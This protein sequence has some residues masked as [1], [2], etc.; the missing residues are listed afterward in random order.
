MVRAMLRCLCMLSTVVLLAGCRGP[1]NFLFA[2]GTA[3][4]RLARLGWIALISFSVV[5]VV[6]WCLLVA[7]V[8]RRRG[9][10]GE[11]APVDTT[12]G[13]NWIIVGGLIVPITVLSTLFFFSLDTLR[14]FPM[15]KLMHPAPSIRVTARQWWFD[16]EYLDPSLP[17]RFHAP[18]ELHIPAGAPVNLELVTADVI[19]SFWVPKL[20]GKVDMV[21]GM[22]NR[23][24]LQADHPGIYDGECGEYCGMQ[25]AHMR[26]R[27][28]ADTP[29][30]YARWKSRQLADA[31]EPQTPAEQ[32]GK[33]D[34]MAAPCAVCHTIRG[35][36]A[37]GTVGPDLTHVGSRTRIAGGMLVNNTA[38]LQAW[39]VHAQSFKPGT[40]MPDI[41]SLSGQQLSE[42][43]LYLQ[44]LK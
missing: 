44:S 16:A 25:H 41:N 20:H 13:I 3:A 37:H 23:I 39:I 30:D 36:D 17:N 8:S 34:F 24:R 29:A 43:T 1:Q 15:G 4:D 18:T 11:H 42:L 10:F 40:Q 22:T 33:A 21:P 28:F 31:S 9:S 14:D 2:E 19:H 7:V 12:S 26:L 35:T 6:V 5:T 32:R 38:N 27:V